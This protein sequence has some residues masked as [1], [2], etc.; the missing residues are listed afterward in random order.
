MLLISNKYYSENKMASLD[1]ETIV[2]L[3]KKLKRERSKEYKGNK[4]EDPIIS[5]Y[6][7]A[8]YYG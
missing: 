3:R 1:C 4:S 8:N 6:N 7:P 2:K 5:Q